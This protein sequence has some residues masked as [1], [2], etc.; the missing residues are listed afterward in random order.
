MRTDVFWFWI[1]A[2]SILLAASCDGDAEETP[3]P[4]PTAIGP[5]ATPTPAGTLIPTPTATLATTPTPTPTPTPDPTLTYYERAWQH[6][7]EASFSSHGCPASPDVTY[8]A[9]YYQGSLI[10]THLHMPQLPST[11]LGFEKGERELAGF[12]ESI[13]SNRDDYDTPDDGSFPF[14]EQLP[15]AGKNTTIDEIACTL[16]A[17]G[18]NR[19]FSYFSVFTSQPDNVLEIARIA[20]ERYPGLFVPFVN[21]PGEIDGVTTV[22]GSRLREVLSAYPGVFKG[23]GEVRLAADSRRRPDDDPLSDVVLLRTVYPVADELGLMGYI[24]PEDGQ[25]DNL[26]DALAAHPNVTFIVHGDQAQDRIG[27]LM[28]AFPRL[29]Q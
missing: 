18:T 2:I 7:V 25:A 5:T 13:Y 27:S 3:V 17:D 28:D 15:I 9:D 6:R 23:Y 12:A 19:A 14:L 26:A 20:S 10:D 4:T 1:L 8:P 29:R 11:P 24:H 16:Q 21:S 22:D